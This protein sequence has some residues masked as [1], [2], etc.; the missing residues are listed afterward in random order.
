M[1]DSDLAALIEII[2]GGSS[3][4]E[5]APRQPKRDRHDDAVT[6]YRDAVA[7][8]RERDLCEGIKQIAVFLDVK[9]RRAYYLCESAAVPAFKRVGKWCLR[10]SAYEK[11]IEMLEADAPRI[12]QANKKKKRGANQQS[13]PAST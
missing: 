1:P 8:Y 10:P 12:A 9:A 11:H 5:P 2:Q 7:L 13:E 4:P 3:D 6:L